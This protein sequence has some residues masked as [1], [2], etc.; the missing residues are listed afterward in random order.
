VTGIGVAALTGRRR[1]L[2]GKLL[3]GAAGQV[4]LARLM[5]L[6][7]DASPIWL[8]VAVALVAGVPQGRNTL[9]LQNAVYR[10][11]TRPASRPR[12]G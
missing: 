5:L 2:R 9:A 8:I 12:P 10:R 6:L 3:V 1:E 7:G 11:A 4:L